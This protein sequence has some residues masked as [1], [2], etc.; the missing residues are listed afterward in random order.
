[1]MNDFTKI[2]LLVN[3]L[4]S[5]VQVIDQ[6]SALIVLKKT[7]YLQAIENLKSFRY[8]HT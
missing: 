7:T 5:F 4:S 3:I 8:F 2:I 6:W 1:M